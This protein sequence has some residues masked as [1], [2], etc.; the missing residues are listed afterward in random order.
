MGIIAQALSDATDEQL[1]ALLRGLPNEALARLFRAWP[2]DVQIQIATEADKQVKDAPNVDPD[3]HLSEDETDE[4]YR[5]YPDTF[6]SDSKA[7]DTNT[8]FSY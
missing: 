4:L 5:Y 2:I 6:A 8:K 7:A 3:G 1:A